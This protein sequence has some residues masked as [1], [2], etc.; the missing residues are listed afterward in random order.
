MSQDR[1]NHNTLNLRQALERNEWTRAEIIKNQSGVF[2]GELEP[3]LQAL[4]LE[5]VKSRPAPQGF[6][7]RLDE[8]ARNAGM[9][10]SA[11][12]EKLGLARSA[13][14]R[15]RNGGGMSRGVLLD[16]SEVLGVSS[17]WL[18]TGEAE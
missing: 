8:S 17:R 6:Y 3:F 2:I 16:A 14:T 12:A 18:E 4:G 5:V 7:Q 13:A 9:S 15:W 1:S 11:L 10:L